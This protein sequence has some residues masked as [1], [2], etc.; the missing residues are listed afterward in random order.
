MAPSRIRL[1]SL[2]LSPVVIGA[3]KPP[4]P[5]NAA[6]VAVAHVDH[7]ARADPGEDGPRR[8]RQLDPEESRPRGRAPAPR[9]T[10]RARAGSRRCPP[11]CCARSARDR[12]ETGQQSRQRPGAEQGDEEAQQRQRGDGLQRRPWRRAQGDPARGGAPRPR[13]R[14]ARRGAVARSSERATSPR[15]AGPPSRTTL[16]MPGS[17]PRLRSGGATASPERECNELLGDGGEGA[18]VELGLGVERGRS[19]GRRSC[20]RAREWPRTTRGA[21]RAASSR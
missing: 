7:R 1:V 13:C 19:T 2:R 15:C 16:T 18:A 12:R 8:E 10:L 4:A 14:A 11:P 21:R 3:P 20:P 5:M 9:P 17:R 6:R